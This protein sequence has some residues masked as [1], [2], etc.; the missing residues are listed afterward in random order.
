M[1]TF[2]E[3]GKDALDRKL[4]FYKIVMKNFIVNINLM[5]NK[6]WIDPYLGGM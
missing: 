4:Q 6:K 3:L 1:K 5:K 2:Q